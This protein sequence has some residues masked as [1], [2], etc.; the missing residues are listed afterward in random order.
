MAIATSL[1]P[2]SLRA[3]LAASAI[4]P[5]DAPIAITIRATLAPK[6]CLGSCLTCTAGARLPKTGTCSA[7]KTAICSAD[8]SRLN[9]SPSCLNSADRVSNSVNCSADNWPSVCSTVASA[10]ILAL[11]S[12][13]LRRSSKILDMVFH[14]FWLQK[15]RHKALELCC[16]AAWLE[17]QI[18]VNSSGLCTNAAAAGF[19]YIALGNAVNGVLC[20][21]DFVNQL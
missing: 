8:S 19:G 6:Y 1:S 10:W 15:K 2:I 18:S 3:N 13:R 21:G 11:I 20:R 5:F 14:L 7:V 17:L 4:S 16:P 9:C 12:A